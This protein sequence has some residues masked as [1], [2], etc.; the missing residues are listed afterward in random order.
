MSFAHR[1]S[2][3]LMNMGD[4]SRKSEVTVSV[5]CDRQ[6]IIVVSWTKELGIPNWELGT[7]SL[8]DNV[9]YWVTQISKY[10]G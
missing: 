7:D 4:F 9:Y 6:K 10:L 2:I 3:G 1:D 5:F 8:V